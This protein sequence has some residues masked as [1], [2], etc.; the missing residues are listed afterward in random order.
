[1]HVMSY[2]RKN[3]FSTVLVALPK[4][5]VFFYNF[6]VIL[7]SAYVSCIFLSRLQHDDGLLILTY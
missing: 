6:G 4:K 5:Q 3:V 2:N 7:L 1:M